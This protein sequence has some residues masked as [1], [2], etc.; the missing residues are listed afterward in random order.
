MNSLPRVINPG[1]YTGGHV[2]GVAVDTKRGYAY[3]SFTTQLVKTD[4]SGNFIGSVVNL[5]GH[6]GCIS[7]TD[8][9]R[10]VGSLEY[11]SDSIG[12]GIA[13]AQGTE[14]PDENAFYLVIFDTERID[15][16][17]IDADGC[18]IMK[19]V[20]LPEPTK[21]YAT[22]DEASGKEHKYG[23][24]GIDGTGIGPV[25]GEPYGTESFISVCYGIYGDVT[26]KDNDYQVIH[27]YPLSVFGDFG[28][29]LSQKALHKSGPKSAKHTHFLYTGNTEWGIQNLEYDPNSDLWFIAVYRGKKPEFS[30]F[31][32]FCV[33]G[34]EKPELLSLRGRGSECGRVIKTVG[35]EMCKSGLASGYRFPYGSTGI[36]S[37][38]G[39]Y[40]Y[41][42]HHKSRTDEHGKQLFSSDLTLYRHVKGSDELF[43]EA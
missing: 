17:G 25:F 18:D 32:M 29:P 21:D 34:S 22:A 5:T 11:K 24:S 3:F 9:G 13:A 12:R 14:I 10:V 19:A 36:A 39:G 7:L 16:Q 38:S 2:Q 37:V 30:N 41:I 1:E 40:F 26:R 8:D 28:K 42:S 4:L 27:S 20:L 23:C 35:G 15:R 43:E 6:L 33:R 31:D